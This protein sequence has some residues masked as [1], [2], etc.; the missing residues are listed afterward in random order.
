MDS[1]QNLYVFLGSCDT[2]L[3]SNYR[4][5]HTITPYNDTVH[6]PK[7]FWQPEPTTDQAEL[8]RRLWVE[9]AVDELV[10]SIAYN[11][12][13]KTEPLLVVQNSEGQTG[14]DLEKMVVIEGNRRLAALKILVDD[15]L[16][17]TL[18]ITSA[19]TITEAAKAQLAASQ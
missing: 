14:P 10:Y 16:R 1:P 8:T 18:K 7:D 2:A 12:Y 5:N 11:S 4:H 6:L 17:E 13:Y 3:A 9:I 19:P 15:H